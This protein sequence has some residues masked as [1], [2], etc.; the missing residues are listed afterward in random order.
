MRLTSLGEEKERTCFSSLSF[1]FFRPCALAK[2][3]GCVTIFIYHSY[4]YFVTKLR[5][6][7][8]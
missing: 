7:F 2:V 3:D 5:A 6:R 1:L 4:R 8:G